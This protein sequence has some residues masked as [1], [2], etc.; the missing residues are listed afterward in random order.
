MMDKTSGKAS[1]LTGNFMFS[2]RLF[3][4]GHFSIANEWRCNRTLNAP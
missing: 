1:H 3:E 2:L 4:T